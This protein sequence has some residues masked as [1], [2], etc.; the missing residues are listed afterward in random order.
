MQKND[1]PRETLEIII[2]EIDSD[3][4][5]RLKKIIKH[6]KIIDTIQNSHLQ[7]YRR[8]KARMQKS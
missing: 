3:L 8:N 7:L 6:F 2:G 4:I 5:I 1:F